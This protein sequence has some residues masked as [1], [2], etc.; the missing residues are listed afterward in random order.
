MQEMVN[1]WNLMRGN[2]RY[3]IIDEPS[4]NILGFWGIWTLIDT[5]MPI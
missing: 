4:L 1:Q 5:K 2:V 3:K